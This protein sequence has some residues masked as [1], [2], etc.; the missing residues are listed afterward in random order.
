MVASL[1]LKV[2]KGCY[3]SCPFAVAKSYDISS[4]EKLNLLYSSSSGRE[5]QV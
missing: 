4:A 5:L 3:D 1:I 2:E